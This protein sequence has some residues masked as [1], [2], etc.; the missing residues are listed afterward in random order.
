[1]PAASSSSLAFLPWCRLSLWLSFSSLANKSHACSQGK[2]GD[3]CRTRLYVPNVDADWEA[4]ARA[5]GRALGEVSPAKTETPSRRPSSGHVMNRQHSAFNAIVDGNIEE[6]EKRVEKRLQPGGYTML[7]PASKFRLLWDIQMLVY[8]V[9]VSL[10]FP[11]Y[12]G[13][14]TEAKGGVAIFELMIDYLFMVDLVLNFRTGYIDRNGIVVLDGRRV[15]LHYLRTW[16]VLDF[17]SSAPL[18]LLLGPAFRNLNAAK[19]LKVGR[20]FK[21]LKM[22]RIGKL[23]KLTQESGVTE[24]LD[25]FM[26]SAPANALFNLRSVASKSGVCPENGWLDGW[27]GNRSA[28]TSAPRLSKNCAAAARLFFTARLRGSPGGKWSTS[29]EQL[30]HSVT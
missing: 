2:L 21:A 28:S 26:V 30:T 27:S 10:L 14:N 20:L 9:Y 29:G 25:E 12:M 23:A 8:V 3:V 24:S 7:H 18:D 1:M 16:F 4:V 15:F 13:F 17:V 6:Y 11:Y 22:L 5:H 19:L